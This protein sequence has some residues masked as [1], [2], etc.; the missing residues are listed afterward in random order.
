MIL[1]GKKHHHDNL[2]NLVSFET[3]AKIPMTVHT[4]VIMICQHVATHLINATGEVVG[5]Y[6][7]TE[8]LKNHSVKLHIKILKPRLI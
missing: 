7:R 3:A 1:C 2:G 5:S 8:S 4:E 6:D